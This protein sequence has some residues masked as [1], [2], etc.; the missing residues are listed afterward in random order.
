MPFLRITQAIEA[1]GN[2]TEEAAHMAREFV[3]ANVQ[4]LQGLAAEYGKPVVGGS[5]C[6]R[7]EL[8]NRMLQ[9]EGFPVLPSPERAVKALAALVTYA[10]MRNRG[11]EDKG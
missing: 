11:A 5:F 6:T 9:D 7:Q 4:A 2:A 10:R 8:L 1:L 3:T